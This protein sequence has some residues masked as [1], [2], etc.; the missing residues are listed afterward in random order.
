MVTYLF[1]VSTFLQ[2]DFF[3]TYKNVFLSLVVG[4]GNWYLHYY[5]GN[6]TFN[7]KLIL[8]VI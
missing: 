8:S 1:Q 5:H 2:S 6:A 4:A 3:T 7:I